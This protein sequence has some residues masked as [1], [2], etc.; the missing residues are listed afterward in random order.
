MELDSEDPSSI[1]L[2]YGDRPVE[3]YILQ[4]TYLMLEYILQ[5]SQACRTVTLDLREWERL[6][7]NF[8]SIR[9]LA[10][11]R[12]NSLKDMFDSDHTNTQTIKSYH[13]GI[14]ICLDARINAGALTDNFFPYP[15]T[16]EEASDY[17]SDIDILHECPLPSLPTGTLP[18]L[19]YTPWEEFVKTMK[20]SEIPASIPA[21]WSPFD[22][23]YPKE[24]SD[25]EGLLQATWSCDICDKSHCLEDRKHHCA[26]CKDFDLC[27]ECLSLPSDKQIVD[28]PDSGNHSYDHLFTCQSLQFSVEHAERIAWEA[29]TALEDLREA[30]SATRRSSTLPATS[31]SVCGS[32]FEI[33]SD[34]A[35]FYTCLDRSCRGLYLCMKC[36]QDKKDATGEH[37]LQHTLLM[38]RKE[39]VDV[40]P[41]TKPSTAPLVEE[42]PDVQ[43]KTEG[44]EDPGHATIISSIA[45]IN[46]RMNAMGG[47]LVS[48]HSALEER[49]SKIESKMDGMMTELKELLMA[50]Q[51][52]TK[53]S[54]I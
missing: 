29:K 20:E 36:V 54:T 33:I 38:V 53:L 52:T 49:M 41:E 27:F 32:C 17:L 14:W 46:A 1:L 25:R 40:K 9:N 21:T 37:Q 12:V 22:E 2:V 48:N 31:D 28:G 16:L 8:K 45:D 26:E 19:R 43:S 3:T 34:D 11:Q 42:S 47:T 6:T 39:L 51:G 4:V 44:A 10:I 30:L 23:A 18:Y 7:I 15:Y 5:I 13:G 50:L 35:R 24:L